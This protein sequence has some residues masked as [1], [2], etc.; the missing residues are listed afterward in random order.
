MKKVILILAL[1]FLPNLVL[2]QEKVQPVELWFFRQDGCPYCAQAQIF[3]QQLK[4]DFPNLT[5][6]DYEVS[7]DSGNAAVFSLMIK[8]YGGEDVGVPAFFIGS[9][10]VDGF[11]ES[12][13]NSVRQTVEQC[14]AVVCI[15]PGQFLKD[16]KPS[17]VVETSKINISWPWVIGGVCFLIV[18]VAIFV[19]HKKVDKNQ[20]LN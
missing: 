20:D 11:N 3:L 9:S 14:S 13:G 15:S 2:A 4:T 19:P 8:A 10:F 12:I 7:Q 17:N 1:L 5:I 16:Y 6:R 18:V